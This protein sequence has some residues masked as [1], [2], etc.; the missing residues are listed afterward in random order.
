MSKKNADHVVMG[1]NSL[2]CLHCGDEHILDLGNGGISL[3]MMAGLASGYA[4]DHRHCKPSP[5]G[6]ARFE[7]S[8]PDEWAKSWDTGASSMT[9][10]HFMRSGL[11]YRAAVPYDL[12]DFGRCY[13]LLKTSPAWRARMSEMGEAIPSWAALA[14]NWDEL[15]R[16]YE[17]EIRC[18]SGSASKLDERLEKLR[19]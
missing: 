1:N 8:T 18:G 3:N 15:E 13:R 19:S 17:E 4:D 11:T 5:R 6:V 16:L 10:Y 12:S 9:I 7:Y 2:R 14:S